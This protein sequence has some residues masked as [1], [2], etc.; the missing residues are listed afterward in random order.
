MPI[1]IAAA[2]KKA[3]SAGFL[4]NLGSNDIPMTATQ[5]I[6]EQIGA[7]FMENLGK[8]ANEKQVVASGALLRD[9]TFRIIN[10][11]TL[12]IMMPDY[13]DY[14][15]EGVKGVK[16]SKNAPGSPY[17][18]KNYGMND[19]GRKSI[20]GYI[21]SGHVK[22]RNVKTDKAYGIGRE[23][24]HKKLID[25]QTDTLIYLIKRQ[26]IKKTEYFN[27][28]LQDT[29][30]DIDSALGQALATDISISLNKLN[31]SRN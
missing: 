11:D 24:K 8:R 14:P 15:N 6:L 18:F 29:L 1:N 3:L 2:Q 7:F 5:N 28:A 30:K 9:A 20:R 17:Q 16:S 23:G 31:V 12:Q 22:I 13:F 26:G 27:I 25:V 19:T 21:V 10:D 4:D